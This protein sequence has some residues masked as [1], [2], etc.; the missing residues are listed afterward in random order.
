MSFAFFIL[1]HGRPN[2]IYTLK[3]LNDAG[4][5]SPIYLLVDDK[6]KTLPEY[7]EKYGDMVKVFSKDAV[8]KYTDVGDNFGKQ[9]VILYARNACF[10]VAKDLGIKYFIQLDDDYTGFFYRFDSNLKY[11][12][13]K[14]NL[15]EENIMAM[16]KFMDRSKS[17]SVAMA[18]GGDF[19]GGRSNPHGESPML[20]RKCM[21][22]FVCSMDR[23]FK[24][25]GNINED[26][27]TYVKLGSL[28][29]L[30]F[31]LSHISLNQKQTQTNSGGMTES[32]LDNGTYVKSFYSV[33]Y[34]PSSVKI[35]LMQAKNKRLHHKVHW[36]NAVP[37]IVSE[38]LKK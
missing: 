38:S 22:S 6:D 30:M 16:I 26:V 24:F 7:Q 27:N 12:F 1:T 14:M 28:G 17:L 9:N 5:K 35:C 23:P 10:D 32:Y 37:V 19:I 3:V 2:K 18:Q 11:C 15:I 31:T 13:K 34:N 21:N 36:N 33:M 20:L 29:H 4:V 25:F 8:A